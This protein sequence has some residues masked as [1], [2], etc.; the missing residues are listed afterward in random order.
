VAVGDE[1][2][3]WQEPT[4]AAEDVIQDN[5]GKATIER[6]AN[7]KLQQRRMSSKTTK[8]KQPSKESANL[9]LPLAM[10]QANP[11]FV[12][13]KLMLTVDVLHKAGHRS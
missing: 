2:C 3:T 9:K 7:L 4:T 13:G 6:V 12:M 5:K 8:G 10:M 11:K 1:E